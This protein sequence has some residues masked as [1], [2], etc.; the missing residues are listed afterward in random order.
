MW[1]MDSGRAAKLCDGTGNLP[2][3]AVANHLIRIMGEWSYHFM[4]IQGTLNDSNRLLLCVL[5]GIPLTKKLLWNV[6]N[7]IRR[8]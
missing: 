3:K 8:R 6:I 7:S 1:I 4:D 5:S 2:E